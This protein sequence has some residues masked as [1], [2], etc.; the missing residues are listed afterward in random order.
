VDLLNKNINFNALI[1]HVG[2]CCLSEKVCG[3]CD[4]DNCL[5][6]YCEQSLLKAFKSNDEYIDDGMEYIPVSDTKLY[7]EEK[8]IDAIGFILNECK[9]CQLY[10]DEDCIINIIRSSLEVALLGDYMDYKGSS[11]IYFKDLESKDK[12][13]S[14][15]V[16]SAF[17]KYNK[18]NLS[19][20]GV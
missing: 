12:E 3:K 19:Y 7:D 14:Q 16:F 18:T 4:K 8:V 13:I 5:I 9:N 1:T 20:E 6:G 10:H 15:K 11:L 2:E 17:N